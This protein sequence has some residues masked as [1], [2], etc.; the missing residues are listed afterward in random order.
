MLAPVRFLFAPITALLGV[1]KQ[2]VKDFVVDAIEH[3]TGIDFELIEEL[4]H[5]NTKM[6][7]ASVTINGTVIPI[8]KA[9]DHDKLDRYMGING[10]AHSAGV[11]AARH[12]RA[13]TSTTTPSGVSTTTSS[14]TRT[15]FAAYAERASRWPRCCCCR[16]PTRSATAQRSATASSR[17]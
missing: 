5:M 17:C 10:I 16:S 9:G 7:L 1:A 15:K 13:S 6:D 3:F 2:V 12:R 11:H 8:F 14:S 4:E